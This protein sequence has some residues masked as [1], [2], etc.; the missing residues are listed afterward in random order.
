MS[1]GVSLKRPGIDPETKMAAVLE[2]LKGERSVAHICPK[3]QTS[4]NLYYRWRWTCPLIGTILNEKISLFQP[5][6]F[7]VDSVCPPGG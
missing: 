7:M 4:E 3:Y 5:D 1:Q 6:G 2:G